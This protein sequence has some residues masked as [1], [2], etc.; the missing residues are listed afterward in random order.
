MHD[1]LDSSALI[2]RY[3]TEQGTTWVRSITLPSAG[4]TIILAQV[5][6]VEIVSGVF[7]RRR[8][9]LI[10]PRTAQAI[11]L[12][13]HRHVKRE[14]MVVELTAPIIQDAEAPRAPVRPRGSCTRSASSARTAA[15]PFPRV[16]R[17]CFAT[18]PAWP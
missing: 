9:G 2:K 7:R 10:P 4:H 6:Q 12:L 15:G 3:I 17:S 14:Y 8:E 13:L 11:R 5:T 16:V 1:F 18:L